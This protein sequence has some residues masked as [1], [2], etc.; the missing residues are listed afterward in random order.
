MSD[1]TYEV[2]LFDK[3]KRKKILHV[4][5]LKKWYGREAVVP[6]NYISED[7]INEGAIETEI[8]LWEGGTPTN[9]KLERE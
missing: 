6:I 4:N 5:M 1:V 8:P 2:D 7:A 3:K 9:D